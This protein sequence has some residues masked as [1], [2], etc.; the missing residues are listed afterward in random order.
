[1]KKEVAVINV[2]LPKEIVSWLDSLIKKNQYSSRSEAL[3][4]FAREYV[5]GQEHKK[6]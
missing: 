6:T 5:E 1:M 2:R 4:E 3:R